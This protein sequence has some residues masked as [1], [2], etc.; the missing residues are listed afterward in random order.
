MTYVGSRPADVC[1][2]ALSDIVCLDNDVADC[3]S[4]L[5]S[6]V[7]GEDDYTYWEHRQR[8]PRWRLPLASVADGGQP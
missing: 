7:Q 6:H 5:L 1:G 4:Q 3:M 8:R 2:L